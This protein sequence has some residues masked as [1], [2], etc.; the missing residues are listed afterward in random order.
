MGGDVNQDYF[1]D[2]I[3]EDIITALSHFPNL[4]VIARNSTFT[5][6]GRAVDV[7]QVG[8]DLGVRYVLEGS[9]RKA[10]KRVRI[11]GQL[12]DATTGATL[13]ADRFD[14]AHEDVFELQDQMARSVVGAI[15]PKLRQAEIE[16]A[17]RKPNADLNA[18]DYYL[19]GLAEF[20]KRTREGTD[21]ALLLLKEAITIDPDF[22]S[23]WGLAA[24]CYQ[25]RKV[26]GW[27]IHPEQETAEAER[28]GRRAAELGME[29]ADALSWSALT[30][31]YV[32][33][34][35]ETGASLVARSLKLNPNSA[36]AW[37]YDAWISGWL[38]EPDRAIDSATRA[39]RLSP[40]DPLLC[41]FQ[42]A[43]AYA[44]FF[45]GRYHE[46]IS[47][48]EMSLRERS[49]QEAMRVLA[50]SSALVD[51]LDDARKTVIELRRLNPSL[52]ISDLRGLPFRRPDDWSRYQSGL[53]MAGLPE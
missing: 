41:Y 10:A 4:F 44:H 23:A 28:L 6:K 20:Y 16:R 48:S 27:V 11:T 21:R 52:R 1:V 35:V 22:A 45:A 12:I 34:D 2:G 47:W 17:K 8:R 18:Y 30:L 38:G 5:Y 13:W 43:L 9:G 42:A 33:G 3:V 40:L 19:R 50:A 51:R 31:A 24:L 29:D 46:A 26:N 53:R 7:K 14:G 15:A 25:R 36:T 39:M 37:S 49:N 32:V